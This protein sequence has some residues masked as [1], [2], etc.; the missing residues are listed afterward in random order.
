MLYLVPPKLFLGHGGTVVELEVVHGALHAEVGR[1]ASNGGGEFGVRS[2]QDL[3]RQRH[4]VCKSKP[5]FCTFWETVIK[6][7]FVRACSFSD[8]SISIIR[9][10]QFLCQIERILLQALGRKRV[11]T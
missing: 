3:E 1:L 2:F 7:C 9:I 11:V 6:K 8:P 5:F 4:D 10:S